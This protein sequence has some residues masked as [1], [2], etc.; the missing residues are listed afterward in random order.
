MLDELEGSGACWVGKGGAG[1]LLSGTASL[2]GRLDSKA[3]VPAP[4]TAPAAS[5]EME[6]RGEGAMTGPQRQSL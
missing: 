1:A 3:A 4:T 6:K 5:S 2:R